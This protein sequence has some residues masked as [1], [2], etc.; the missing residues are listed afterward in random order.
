MARKDMIIMSRRDL[1]RL[2]YIKLALEKKLTQAKVGNLTG[3]S[4]RQIRRLIKRLRKEGDTGICHRSR[5]RPSNRRIPLEPHGVRSI[6][7]DFP[8][9]KH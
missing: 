8:F 4:D 6:M 1:S 7:F 5:G 9:K 3:L 2:H